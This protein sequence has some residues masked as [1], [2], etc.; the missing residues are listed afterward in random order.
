MRVESKITS[1][2]WI[3]LESVSGLGK[4]LFQLGV[5]HYDPPPPDRLEDVEALRAALRFRFANILEAWADFDGDVPVA[6]GRRGGLLMGSSTAQLGPVAVTV[7]GLG[8]PSLS[9]E[10]EVGDGWIRFRQTAGGRTGFPLPRRL[11]AAPFLRLQ[12]P[13]VWTTLEL[14][15]FGDGSAHGEMS[16]ASAFPRHWV[17]DA[18]D[19]LTVKSGITDWAGWLAQPSW[20]QTPWGDQDAVAVVTPAES[21]LEREISNAMLDGRHSAVIRRVAR[22][23]IVMADGQPGSSVALILDGLFAVMT[24]DEVIAEIGPGVVIGEGAPLGSGLRS[25]TVVAKTPG[26]LAEVPAAELDHHALRD[27][28]DQHDRANHP[29]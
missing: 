17:Y 16:G 12:A 28:A 19:T 14:T 2:S 24:H 23:Q 25:A 29:D 10:P 20:H 3:P 21:G 4:R 1:V 9:P 6:Y 18:A 8:L 11:S 26:R 7:K 5:S 13:I 27:L 22:G 15:L